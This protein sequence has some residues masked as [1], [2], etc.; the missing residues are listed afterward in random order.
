M[1]APTRTFALTA[2][3]A[4]AA[5]AALIA[6]VVVV[7]GYM[8]LQDFG[9]WNYQGYVLGRA[10]NGETLGVATLKD[11]PV[12]YSLG[13]LVLGGLGA[14][15]PPLLAGIA[16]VAVQVLLGALAVAAVV[17]SRGLDWR[18]ATPVLA[19]LVILGSGLWN[20]YAAHQIGLAVLTAWL[21]VPRE[22]RSSAAVVLVFSLLT[23][24]SHALIFFSF[25]VAAGVLALADRRLLRVLL[26][27]IPSVALTLWYATNSPPEA[28]GGGVSL[29]TPVDWVTYKGYTFAKS[30][31][32]Q[33][34]IVNGVGDDRT[35]MLV[36][37]AVNAATV[38]LVLV[39]SALPLLARLRPSTWRQHPDLLAGLA[40][41]VIGLA[42]PAFFLGI[43]NPAERVIGPGLLLLAVAAL[44]GGRWPALRVLTAAAA[45]A[46]LLLTGVSSATLALKSDR[47]DAAPQDP[48][49]TFDESSGSRTDLLFGHRLDQMETRYD[50]ARLAWDE[51]AEPSVPLIFDEGLLSPSSAVHPCVSHPDSRTLR[52]TAPE[53][54]HSSPRLALESVRGGGRESCASAS[55]ARRGSFGSIQWWPRPNMRGRVDSSTPCIQAT[56]PRPFPMTRSPA[57]T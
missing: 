31:G 9:E 38:G 34:L 56:S 57:T 36:G 55:E 41:I 37:A 18:V 16:A 52:T 23:F 35:L 4:T 46:G 48:R 19:T 42:L 45:C 51:D 14:V 26:A 11:Y 24:F 6:P 20:G 32:Y 44:E 49:P 40:L 17:R 13:N 21:A 8:A 1:P 15:V 43:V 33:N 3:A 54:P 53:V 50:A 27:A 2:T 5:A 25:A 29:S 39:C 30:G 22:R 28:A 47:G 7:I 10:F 12:P